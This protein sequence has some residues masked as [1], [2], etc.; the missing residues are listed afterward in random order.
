MEALG[1]KLEVMD[2]RFHRLLHLAALGRHDLA[3]E[4]RDRP[5]GHL[6]QT[7]FDDPHRLADFLDAD[8][9]AVVTIAA[10]AHRHVELHRG[11]S[12][13]GLRLAQIPGDAGGADHRARKAPFDRVFSA[14][15][16]DIDVALFED[17]VVDDQFHRVFE[18]HRHAPVDPIADVGQQLQGH[19][20]M[21]PAGAEPSG[22]H[23]RARG[24]FVEIEDVFAQ[25]IRPQARRQRADV[26]HMARKIEHVVRD[27]REFREQHAQILRA[28][29]HFEIEQFLDREHIAMLHAHRRDVI[30]P[31][32][33]GQSLEIGF[34]FDQLFGAAVEQADMRI[35]PLDDLAVQ[36]HHQPQHAVRG[37]VLGAE[38]DR[39]ILDRDLARLGVDRGVGAQPLFAQIG[40]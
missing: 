22:V 9:E 3:I 2:Q 14:H 6:R 30:E 4:A 20:L 18:E 5:I 28:R 26:D 32:E 17:A 23:P 15:H 40:H 24:A 37:R 29:G 12:V 38:I 13:I 16:R 33:I 21:H 25:L 36:L 27:A 35:E 19:V 31:I 10:R 1:V 11:I 39:V 8:H 34:I 7:L